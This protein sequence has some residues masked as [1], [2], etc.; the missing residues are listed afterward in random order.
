[1]RGGA[2]EPGSKFLITKEFEGTASYTTPIPKKGPNTPSLN[3]I[4]TLFWDGG[5]MEGGIV[6]AY[7]CKRMVKGFHKALRKGPLGLK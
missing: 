7:D 3:L 2:H 4:R 6:E 1:M 5:G